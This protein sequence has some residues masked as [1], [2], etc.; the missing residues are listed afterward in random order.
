MGCLQGT[1]TS[2]TQNEKVAS[3][4]GESA[5]ELQDSANLKG[6]GEHVQEDVKHTVIQDESV[7][8]EDS[9]VREDTAVSDHTPT[10]QDQYEFLNGRLCFL[11]PKNLER[12]SLHILKWL[13]LPVLYKPN[14]T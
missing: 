3:K 9:A 12:K 1:C 13:V 6:E 8:V 4:D 2:S 5:D 11:L 14:S 10:V 7:S